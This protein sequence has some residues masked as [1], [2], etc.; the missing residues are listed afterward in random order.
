MKS[1]IKAHILGLTASEE[2][3]HFTHTN[4]YMKDRIFELQR[5]I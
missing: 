3:A 1:K 4:E 5:T 2:T